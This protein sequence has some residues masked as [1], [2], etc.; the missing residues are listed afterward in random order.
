MNKS[1]SILINLKVHTD[2]TI[3]RNATKKSRVKVWLHWTYCTTN[4]IRCLK[5]FYMVYL[6]YFF[7]SQA[8]N[9][10]IYIV[11]TFLTKIS[12]KRFNFDNLYTSRFKVN[13]A[14]NWSQIVL[15]NQLGSKL[16]WSRNVYFICLVC[17]FNVRDMINGTAG[18][19]AA[20]S[21]FSDTWTLFQSRGR[22]C[23]PICFVSPKFFHGYTPEC[24]HV[25]Y[26]LASN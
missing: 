5:I 14:M 6:D 4:E 24:F 16:F 1:I 22:L 7:L 21:K 15:V 17:T 20:L 3:G 26:H 19:T 11:H 12:L 9:L 18:K 8:N 25:K 10:C 23:P 13:Q 2:I